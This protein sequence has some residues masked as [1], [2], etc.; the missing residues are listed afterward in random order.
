LEAISTFRQRA[1]WGL[2]CPSRLPSAVDDRD[3]TTR[4]RESFTERNWKSRIRAMGKQV[5][6][7]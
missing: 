4:S 7:K 6:R 1:T 5:V 3:H 2:Y